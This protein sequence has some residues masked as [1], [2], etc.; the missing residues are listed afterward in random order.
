MQIIDKKQQQLGDDSKLETSKN[1]TT[2]GDEQ[3]H[4]IQKQLQTQTQK[5]TDKDTIHKQTSIQTSIQT[6][7]NNNNKS[8]QQNGIQRNKIN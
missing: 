5:E 3:S 4:E 1:K 2:I 8:L 6:N 7:N